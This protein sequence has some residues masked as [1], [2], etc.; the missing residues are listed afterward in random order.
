TQGEQKNRE[1]GQ[2][3]MQDAG[4]QDART[5]GCL[6]CNGV[7]QVGGAGV[8]WDRFACR[9]TPG[10]GGRRS[11]AGPRFGR[12]IETRVFGCIHEI[13]IGG[14]TVMEAQSYRQMDEAS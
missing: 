1:S 2:W 12:L 13:R 9:S 11:V 6:C 8:L 5:I 3:S 7:V 14:W 10:R 4:R